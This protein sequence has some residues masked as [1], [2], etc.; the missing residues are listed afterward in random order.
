MQNTEILKESQDDQKTD[1]SLK[2]CPLTKMGMTSCKS[3]TKYR[4]DREE[5]QC[6][7][8]KINT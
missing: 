5:R 8:Y 4:G 6:S 7:S 3:L 1:H 2:L